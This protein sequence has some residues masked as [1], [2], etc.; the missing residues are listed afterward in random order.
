[1][2]KNILEQ[3]KNSKLLTSQKIKI[4]FLFSLALVAVFLFSLTIGSVNVGFSEVVSA[5]FGDLHSEN[6]LII[7]QIRLPRVALAIAVGGGLSVAGAVLQSVL[8]NPLAEPY[9]LGIS[10]GGTFAALLS[11]LLGF[12]FFFTQLF[13]FA[14]ALFVTAFILYLGSKMRTGFQPTTI[15]LSGVM[16]GAFFGA[17]IL[18]TVTLMREN[19]Q[20]ALFWIVGTL[21]FAKPAHSYYAFYVSGFLSFLI[22]LRGYR[23]NLIAMENSDE[24]TLGINMNRERLILLGLSGILTGALVSVSGV[25]GFVGMIVPHIIRNKF[26]F[27]NRFVLPFSFLG[28]AILLLASDTLARTIILPGELPVGAITAFFGTP[29]FIWLIKKREYGFSF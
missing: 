8:K 28:G 4:L 29:V 18:I 11:M 26:G 22:F 16:I 3:T 13:A 6:A 27:D 7:T 20:T 1:M 12:S 25:I 14:G 23:L 5:L 2:A 15:L 9:V 19:L 24:Q 17:A 21:S 10:G